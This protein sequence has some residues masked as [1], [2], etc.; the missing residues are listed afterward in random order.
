[1]KK[2]FLL[3]AIMLCSAAAL[4]WQ[5]S[6]QTSWNGTT[7]VDG[8][9]NFTPSSTTAYVTMSSPDLGAIQWCPDQQSGFDYYAK[10]KLTN[11]TTVHSAERRCGGCA[12]SGL[13]TVTT[14]ETWTLT[15]GIDQVGGTEISEQGPVKAYAA[16]TQ[17]SCPG[18]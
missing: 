8:S 17:V 10:A 11:G 5:Y 13:K 15:A 14:T 6:T 2:Y 18:S 12:Y 1:M 3:A 7:H 9:T 16:S 4:A